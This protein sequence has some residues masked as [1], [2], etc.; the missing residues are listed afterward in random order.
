MSKNGK[1]IF[2][3][4]FL[5]ACENGHLKK[6]FRLVMEN[7]T[8]GCYRGFKTISYTFY[9]DT[10]DIFN[11]IYI[12]KEESNSE[13]EV[14]YL[15][16]QLKDFLALEGKVARKKREDFHEGTHTD[17][18][19]LITLFYKNKVIYQEKLPT[20]YTFELLDEKLVPYTHKNNDID[21]S[22][23]NSFDISYINQDA[24]TTKGRLKKDYKLTIEYGMNTKKGTSIFEVY[25][26]TKNDTSY[27]S[28]AKLVNTLERILRYQKNIYGEQNNSLI[29]LNIDLLYENKLIFHK[30]FLTNKVNQNP[31]KFATILN[32]VLVG[33]NHYSLRY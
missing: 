11:T 1:E 26:L 10:I 4:V 23:C 33:R 27:V 12:F 32:R 16:N 17:A 13:K 24:F 21:Y 19:S 20:R 31:M 9:L 3:E 18:H 29:Y 25:H 14:L 2:Q 28:T 5:N 22:S 6:D 30:T 15:Y 8:L 7:T